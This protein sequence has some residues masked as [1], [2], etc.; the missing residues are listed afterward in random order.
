MKTSKHDD[1]L[2]K[3]FYSCTD[4][5]EARDLLSGW[6]FREASL[7]WSN[8]KKVTTKK[9]MTATTKDILEAMQ[10][11]NAAGSMPPFGITFDQPQ[12]IA[13]PAAAAAAEKNDTTSNLEERIARL[14]SRMDRMQEDV[15]RHRNI[16]CTSR[17]TATA[18]SN[19]A[20]ESRSETRLKIAWNKAGTLGTDN[21]MPLSRDITRART[22][23][24]ACDTGTVAEEMSHKKLVAFD[25]NCNS[26]WEEMG[27]ELQ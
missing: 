7:K 2:K 19:R 25:T 10:M 16:G 4:T 9:G 26:S 17:A 18:T 15:Q 22:A 21:E 5:V 1:I 14:E 13:Q 11:L 12:R 8:A 27:A 23:T 3:A 6:H 20:R 24:H